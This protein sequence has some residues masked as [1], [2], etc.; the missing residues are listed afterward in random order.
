MPVPAAFDFAKSIVTL[1]QGRWV[2]RLDG[3]TDTVV[4]L[5]CLLHG[6][7][8]IDGDAVEIAFPEGKP[9][10]NLEKALRIAEE[11]LIVHLQQLHPDKNAE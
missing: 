6:K 11:R 2:N 1:R 8:E 3:L 10:E 5:H 7:V 4:R 9:P